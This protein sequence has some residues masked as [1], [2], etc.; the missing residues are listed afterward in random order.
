[1]NLF[2]SDIYSDDGFSSVEDSS[3]QLN[4]THPDLIVSK[5]Y[6]YDF[7]YNWK[8]ESHDWSFISDSLLVDSGVDYIALGNID[9]SFVNFVKVPYGDGTFYL[10]TNPIVFT[11][12]F[13][14]QPQGY[15]YAQKALS[16]LSGS[17]IFWDEF[18]KIPPRFGNNNVG[19][20]E[21]PLRYILSQASL[22]WSWYVLLTMLLLFVIFKSKRDQR[23]VPVTEENINTSL[24]FIHT[25]GRLYY[26]QNDHRAI[27]L[28][29][30]KLFLAFIRNRYSLQTKTPDNSFIE[31]L[32][33]KSQASRKT[34]GAILEE[35]KTIDNMDDI[36]AE[37]LFSFHSAVET[38]YQ[39]CK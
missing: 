13:L 33:Q 32:S 14:K 26:Q 2:Q 4:F 15:E 18:S 8:K 34:I 1:M 27:A 12:Y 7:I 39:T 17:N 10:H 16:H 30:M 31:K 36:T 35:Y 9:S 19:S 3:V 24:E 11:N 21:T 20:T 5:G 23:I 25:I 22:K 38:F 29:K 28:Q 6:P 37:Q